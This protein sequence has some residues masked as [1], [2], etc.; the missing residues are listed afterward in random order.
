MSLINN[1]GTK[2]KEMKT[3]EQYMLDEREE[4]L[5]ISRYNNRILNAIESVNGE[6]FS[7]SV[8][9]CIEESEANEW[10]KFELIKEPTGEHQDDDN[11]TEGVWVYQWGVGMEGDSWEGYVC[12]KIKDKT[13]LKFRY[14]M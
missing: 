12:I 3:A 2:T 10:H 8:K 1:Q 5:S 9:A 4:I 13:Y 11:I 14:S 7:E 6:D